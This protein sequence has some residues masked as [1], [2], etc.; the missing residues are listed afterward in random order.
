LRTISA[1]CSSTVFCCWT[2]PWIAGWR[3]ATQQ[4]A[5]VVVSGEGVRFLKPGVD[6]PDELE[7]KEGSSGRRYGMVRETLGRQA[8]GDPRLRPIPATNLTRPGWWLNHAA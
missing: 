6:H 1:T 3:R 7:N 4:I 5:I 2:E 8:R